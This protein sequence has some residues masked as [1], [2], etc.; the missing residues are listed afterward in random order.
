MC[1]AERERETWA[2]V[3]GGGGWV[4]VRGVDTE[5]RRKIR[6]RKTERIVIWMLVWV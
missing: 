2:G 3:R 1:V 4:G 6:G 5:A